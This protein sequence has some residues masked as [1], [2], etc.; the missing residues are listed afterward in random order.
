MVV[1]PEESGRKNKK[2]NK[3]DF[4]GQ[5]K[6]IPNYDKLT[7]FEISDS[8]PTRQM[9]SNQIQRSVDVR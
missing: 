2:A 3:G 5:E 4:K 9:R 8:V 7:N 6:S 1:R